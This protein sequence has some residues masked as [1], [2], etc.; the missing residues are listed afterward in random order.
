MPC[1][2]ALVAMRFMC[3]RW[4][5]HYD[6]AMQWVCFFLG[7]G[8]ARVVVVT[9]MRVL[10]TTPFGEDG[11]KMCIVV[12]ASTATCMHCLY[13]RER[14]LFLATEC[15]GGVSPFP[16]HYPLIMANCAFLGALS[17]AVVELSDLVFSPVLGTW[18][19]GKQRTMSSRRSAGHVPTFADC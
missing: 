3:L 12:R 13:I 6:P 8:V 19:V 9:S 10:A 17:I 11:S 4:L 2:G 14:R 1:S 7:G 18:H 15:V 5:S 16:H